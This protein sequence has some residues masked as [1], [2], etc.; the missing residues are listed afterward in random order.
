MAKESI[1]HRRYSQKSD[2]WSYGI[3]IIE[4]YIR[5]TPYPGEDHM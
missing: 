1:E 4:M 3:T 5:S 2:V